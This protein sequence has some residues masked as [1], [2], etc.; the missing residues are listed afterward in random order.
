MRSK[1]VGL[2]VVAVACLG[3]VSTASASTRLTHLTLSTAAGSLSPG[4]PLAL[5]S[6]NLIFETSAGNLEC[7]EDEFDGELLTNDAK[8]DLGTFKEARIEGDFEGIP[9]ACKTSATGPVLISGFGFPWP[10]QFLASKKS[11]IKGSKKIGFRSTF[12]A[13]EGPNNKCAF[14]AMQIAATFN[15]ST[16]KE[17][18]TLTATKQTFK[19]NKHAPEQTSLCPPTGSLSMTAILRSGTERVESQLTG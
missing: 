2:A 17:A 11:K 16:T 4:S 9:G 18:V 12:L 7:E 15:V 3:G 14:E 10:I 8:K 13:L 19:H 6:S 5:F 1:L